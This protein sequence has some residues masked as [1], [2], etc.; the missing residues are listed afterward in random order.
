VATLW[1]GGLVE[2]LSHAAKTQIVCSTL[3]CSNLVPSSLENFVKN[4]TMFEVSS[5][6]ENR[7]SDSSR[8]ELS[9]P[10]AATLI[11]AM[12]GAAATSIALAMA[13]AS[14][15]EPAAVNHFVTSREIGEVKARLEAIEDSSRQLRIELRSDIKEL[16]ELVQQVLKQR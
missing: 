10:A 8:K 15:P 13:P 9:W 3:P 6:E 5:K 14:Q 1:G 7:L 11:A 4:L 12:L 16:R 2:K